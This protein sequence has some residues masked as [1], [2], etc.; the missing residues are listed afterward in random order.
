MSAISDHAVCDECHKPAG[1]RLPDWIHVNVQFVV[2][3]WPDGRS[4]KTAWLHSDC[5][6]QWLERQEISR[7]LN[8]PGGK[9]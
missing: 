5:E 1:Q 8:K 6:Q 7:F 4:E 3:A 9:S 2:V